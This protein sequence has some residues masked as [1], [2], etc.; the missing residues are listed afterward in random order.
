[1]YNAAAAHREDLRWR[2][3]QALALG[4]AQHLGISWD[5]SCNSHRFRLARY[6][7]ILP[8]LWGEGR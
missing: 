4:S 7:G 3:G 8:R 6:N 1:M 5:E 2:S